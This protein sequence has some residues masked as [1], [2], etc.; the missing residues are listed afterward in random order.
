[1]NGDVLQDKK[2]KSQIWILSICNSLPNYLDYIKITS[3]GILY[4]KLKNWEC[5][6]LPYI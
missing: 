2:N 6:F 5:F 4:T 3:L 1:M